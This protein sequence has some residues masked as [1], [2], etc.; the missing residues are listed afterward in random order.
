MNV[1]IKAKIKIMYV[2]ILYQGKSNK[3]INKKAGS[4]NGLSLKFGPTMK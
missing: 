4:S 2:L 3:K 1:K